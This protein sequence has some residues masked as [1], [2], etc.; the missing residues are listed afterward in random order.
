VYSCQGGPWNTHRENPQRGT[1]GQTQGRRREMPFRFDS[2]V[3]LRVAR[4]RKGTCWTGARGKTGGDGSRN[5]GDSV[6]PPRR[7]RGADPDL[8]GRKTEV[9]LVLLRDG[10]L[11]PTAPLRGARPS[12]T[13][14]ASSWNRLQRATVE[15]PQNDA[16]QK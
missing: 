2:G 5:G 4:A 14:R 8:H 10:V 11:T 3:E 13:G 7:T 9:L 12:K 15:R 16:S 6:H 1:W